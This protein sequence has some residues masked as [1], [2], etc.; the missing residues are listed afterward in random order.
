[1][2][3][4]GHPVILGRFKPERR[5]SSGNYSFLYNKTIGLDNVYSWVL[6]YKTTG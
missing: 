5:K 3:V 1:M 6:S 4:S 2:S